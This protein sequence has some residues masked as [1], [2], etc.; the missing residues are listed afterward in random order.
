M[1]ATA[2][3]G[4]AADTT[5]HFQRGFMRSCRASKWNSYRIV[6]RNKQIKYLMRWSTT[7]HQI[8]H[9]QIIRLFCFWRNERKKHTHK[10][11]KNKQQLRELE[12]RVLIALWSIWHICTFFKKKQFFFVASE[13][14]TNH[15]DIATV[16]KMDGG[17]VY[18]QSA[19]A[20]TN[21]TWKER[22]LTSGVTVAIVL[23]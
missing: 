6:E 14:C 12:W 23:R 17:R 9:L 18:P 22:K 11:E 13:R 2:W 16:V 21:Y 4:A 19:S 7:T 1:V 3:H 15:Y 20:A 5:S 8:S 10:K